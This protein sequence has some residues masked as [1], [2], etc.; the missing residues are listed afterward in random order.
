MLCVQ[1]GKTFM[2][3]DRFKFDGT[4]WNHVIPDFAHLRSGLDVVAGA[5][6]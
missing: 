6:A 5:L 2:D 4:V 1:T 3:P